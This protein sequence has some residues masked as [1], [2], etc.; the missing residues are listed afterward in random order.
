MVGDVVNKFTAGDCAAWCWK[1]PAATD[2]PKMQVPAVA[3]PCGA[4]R[5]RTAYAII[6]TQS[7]AWAARPPFCPREPWAYTKICKCSPTCQ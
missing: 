7:Q 4:S 1:T 3:T 2:R 6:D 5:P